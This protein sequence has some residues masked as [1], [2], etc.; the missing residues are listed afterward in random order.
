M[1]FNPHLNLKGKHAFLSASGY[2][3]VN[4][5]I[6]KLET[7]YRN[8]LA[9]QR[10]TDI[11]NFASEAIR[12]GIKL[13]KTKNTLNCYVNDAIGFRMQPEQI[14]YYSDICFGTADA[15]VF[16]DNKLRIHDLK[17]GVSPASFK[18]LEIY[19]ALFCLEYRYNPNDISMELRLYQSNE[20]SVYEPDPIDISAIMDKI[21]E[22]DKCIRRINEEA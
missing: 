2:H 19:A 10:G 11:H 18:Q 14:L 9:V 16:R 15:I 4:Y 12:L 22:F 13:P 17:T 20:V 7:V 5:D 8:S 1:N 21:I 3:W 6:E